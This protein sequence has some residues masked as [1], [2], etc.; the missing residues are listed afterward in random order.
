MKVIDA[1][2][3]ISTNIL[4][5]TNKDITKSY[6]LNEGSNS[7]GFAIHNNTDI[8][9]LKKGGVKI[10]FASIFSVDS[11]AIE[12]LAKE[13]PDNYNFGKVFKI[14]TS[15][16][17]AL[18]QLSLYHDLT[19]NS[20]ELGLIDTQT[21]YRSIMKSRKIGFL[22]HLEGIDY[23]QDSL[24]MVDV[25]YQLGVRSIALTWRNKNYFAGGNNS[26][27]GLTPLGKQLIK[28]LAKTPVVVDL[29]HSN[30]DTFWDV[31]RIADFPLIVSHTLCETITPNSRNLDDEQ[32]K[33]IAKSG[34][35]VCMAA[36]P[37]FI[38]GDTIQDYVKHFLHVI[39]I[40]GSD[41]VGFG[42][43]F[44]GLIDHED[45]FVRNFD[46]SSKFPNVLRELKKAGLTPKDLEKI[47][48]KNLERV[49]LSR[50]PGKG[51]V[52]DV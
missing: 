17:G 18:E 9:R 27:G 22:L 10:V 46:D 21:A 25:F 29:A 52:K 41:H 16:A 13:R 48:Y 44:D 49:I 50:L 45:T 23:F 19:T 2:Q 3:D 42:T 6:H 33:A 51:G 38:G 28:K 20:K 43:D 12:Q 14:R 7:T 11:N 35:V 24:E 8:P 36:I 4:Y 32:I 37:D 31:V 34:G 26:S 30:K 5:A 1:H 15:L 40:V 47:A 39:K